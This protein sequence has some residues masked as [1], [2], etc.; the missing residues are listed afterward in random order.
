MAVVADI[1]QHA[2]SFNP[3]PDPA[4]RS[5]FLPSSAF[6]SNSLESYDFWER[7]TARMYASGEG[8]VPKRDANVEHIFKSRISFFFFY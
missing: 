4:S 6:P 2:S 5:A 8:P 1:R 7:M 3:L